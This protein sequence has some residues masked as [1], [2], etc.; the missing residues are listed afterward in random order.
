MSDGSQKLSCP[1]SI[2]LGEDQCLPSIFNG[3]VPTRSEWQRRRTTLLK[4]WKGVLGTHSMPEFN[5][6]VNASE[7]LG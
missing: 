4:C 3:A 5:G 2:D 6:V 7:T 1:E